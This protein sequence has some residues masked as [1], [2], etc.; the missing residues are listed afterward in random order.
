[1]S[2]GVKRVAWIL[3]WA[4]LGT[5]L[6]STEIHDAART[7]R[8]E[9]VKALLKEKPLRVNEADSRGW[10]PLFL[11]VL[12]GHKPV[13]EYLIA[14]GAVVRV[15]D[16][17]DRTPLHYAAV[18]GNLEIIELLIEKGAVVDAKAIGAA[19]PLNWASQAG[20]KDAGELLIRHGA[21]IHA[22]CNA[23]VTPLYFT[24]VRGYTAFLKLLL[25]HG[26]DVNVV[27]Y[28]GRPAI[29][30]AVVNGHAEAVT[31]LLLHG[32]PLAF[33]EKHHGRSLLHLAV[34][35]GRKNAAEILL[36][37]GLSPNE[38]DNHG[39]TPLDYAFQYH[40]QS[41]AQFL[42]SKGARRGKGKTIENVPLLNK[43]MKPGEAI[44]WRLQGRSW[45]VKTMRHLMVF[46]YPTGL[47]LPQDPSLTNG[48]VV[49]QEVANHSIIYLDS[50]YHRDVQQMIVCQV[51][52]G[53]GKIAIVLN[54]A[55]K[56]YYEKEGVPH[57]SFL[58]SGET[59][60]INGVEISASPSPGVNRGYYIQVDGMEIVWTP[61][62]V[63]HYALMDNFVQDVE[64]L[65]SKSRQIDLLFLGTP[66]GIGPENDLALEG[67]LETLDK[68]KPKA[69]IARGDNHLCRKLLRDAAIKKIKA[70]IFMVENPGDA[71]VYFRG[72]LKRSD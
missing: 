22:K 15:S 67:I 64:F 25:D 69:V 58:K 60:T 9:Q 2:N 52:P 8:L 59:Q 62:K 54:E 35:H 12:E 39:F 43:K 37:K 29:Q 47:Q 50:R 13:V 16:R 17:N 65:A 5:A 49:E 21:N 30:L 42:I 20:Q 27:D 24:A 63:N 45:A 51:D 1:M 34:I 26:A 23:E 41:L 28:T 10:T 70:P 48:H 46:D 66:E 36:E 68:W 61:N 6:W 71:F 38:K 3:V 72:R 32:A 33:R 7:G 55:F 57:T 31:L 56:K 4:V 14:K 44:L 40:H 18:R 19:S 11:A 53:K